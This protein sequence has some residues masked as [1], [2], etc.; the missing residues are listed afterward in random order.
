MDLALAI[1]VASGAAISGTSADRGPDG[2]AVNA[3]VGGDGVAGEGKESK[4]DV[5]LCLD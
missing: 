5:V 3:L 1:V 2:A 4:D